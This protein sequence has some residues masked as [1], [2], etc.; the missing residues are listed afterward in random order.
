MFLAGQFNY[1]KRGILD[2]TH[3]RLF[4]FHSM[5]HLLEQS[6][7]EIVDV[8]GIPAPFP[9]ALGD[10]RLAR[11]MLRLNEALIRLSKPVFSYQMYFA[12]RPLPTVDNLLDV[13]IGHSETCARKAD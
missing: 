5:K 10:G 1:G 6:G 7:Y 3:T 13:S 9:K 8:R 2:K 4:T 11:E 12:A